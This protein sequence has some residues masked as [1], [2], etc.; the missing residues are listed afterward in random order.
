M[1]VSEC[2]LSWFGSQ[3]YL[4]N[5]KFSHITYYISTTGLL[6][7]ARKRIVTPDDEENDLISCI[8]RDICAAHRASVSL[9]LQPV[10]ASLLASHV[11]SVGS[12]SEEALL[13]NLPCLSLPPCLYLR[14]DP[15]IPTHVCL[16]FSP[17]SS[18]ISCL[19][20]LSLSLSL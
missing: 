4:W 19:S 8:S 10:T 14:K 18:E 15:S 1:T 11:L 6:G 7:P 20:S 17:S 9:L 3:V 13:F 5:C 2:V 12:E 16:P